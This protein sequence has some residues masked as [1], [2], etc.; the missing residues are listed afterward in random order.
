M[1]R[2]LFV[3]GTVSKLLI[4]HQFM[5]VYLEPTT[6]PANYVLNTGES[7]GKSCYGYENPG[8]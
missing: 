4:D 2:I 3:F 7:D 6:C 1:R 8:C 5:N